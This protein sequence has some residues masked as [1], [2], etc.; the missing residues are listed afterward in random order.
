VLAAIGSG[1]DGAAAASKARGSRS[2]LVG[3][4]EATAVVE[5]PKPDDAAGADGI[6]LEDAPPNDG[7][8]AGVVDAS[9]AEGMF[10]VAYRSLVAAAG[11]VGVAAVAVVA[12][13]PSNAAGREERSGLSPLAVADEANAG[14]VAEAVVGELP[15]EA[16]P[17]GLAG[18]VEPV[19]EL[20]AEPGSVAAAVGVALAKLGDDEVLGGA[21]PNGAAGA[22]ADAGI[23]AVP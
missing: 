3:T 7:G 22:A 14:G 11:I 9:G 4:V 23:D 19:A 8:A 1:C 12:P 15:A 6:A 2:E 18:G 5:A 10:A 16:T 20:V 13:L 17:Y 21:A